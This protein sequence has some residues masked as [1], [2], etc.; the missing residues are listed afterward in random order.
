MYRRDPKWLLCVFLALLLI[1]TGCS[2][3]VAPPEP[4]TLVFVHS[5]D[6]S[7]S[8]ELWAQQFQDLHPHITVELRTDRRL[9]GID[10]MTATQFEL[11][12]YLE[13][14]AI[15]D[16]STFIEQSE[17]LD[18][19]DY[20]PAALEI[21]RS[22][23]R[24]WAVP[25]GIDMMMLYYSQD[26]F[27]QRG[28]VYPTIGWTWGDF[29][30]RALDV[31]DPGAGIFGYALQHE[32]D[33]AIY[34]PLMLIYQRGGGIFDSLNAPTRV[35]FDA[36][37]N[38]EAMEFYASLI[39]THHVVPTAE[40]A[41]TLGRPYP[42]RGVFDGRFGMWSMMFSE[43][44]GALWEFPWQMNWSI[45]PMPRD[46]AA[47][48]LAMADGLFIS[49]ATEHPAEAWLW[50]EFLSE[51]IPPFAMPARTSLAEST[52]FE[53]R[54]GIAVAEAG[55]AAISDA[56]LVNPQL[57]QFESQLAV[58]AEALTRIRTGEVPPEMALVAAQERAGN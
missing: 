32:G 46:A 1:V 47:G 34:E 58:L 51:Q 30:D 56:I 8:Y 44:G 53:R 5:Q 45:V 52:E 19:A 9:P 11:S 15:L 40:E 24:Q 14:D 18:R 29:L 6:P 57:L 36:P 3:A 12:G 22:Q 55:R 42:W 38:I 41:Q 50:V 4:V 31:T 37:L 2:S 54:V 35:T 7:G 48:T 33:L 26:L 39:H 28:V 16:L 17:T 43:R 13:A 21:F 49:S 27:D 23:G 20:Y 25:F 10:V